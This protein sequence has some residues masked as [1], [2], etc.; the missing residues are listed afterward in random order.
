M[1]KANFRP[2]HDRAADVFGGVQRVFRV[3]RGEAGALAFLVVE[4]IGTKSDHEFRIDLAIQIV[5]D[6]VFRSGAAQHTGFAERAIGSQFRG[7]RIRYVP[8]HVRHV[9]FV[10]VPSLGSHVPFA[11]EFVIPGEIVVLQIV[12]GI[13]AVIDAVR[14]AVKIVFV[15]RRGIIQAENTRRLGVAGPQRHV[16]ATRH[17]E[18]YDPLRVQFQRGVDARVGERID[19]VEQRVGHVVIVRRQLCF[20]SWNREEAANS[21]VE[22]IFNRKVEVEILQNRIEAVLFVGLQEL[23]AEVALRGRESIVDTIETRHMVSP[24]EMA[25][26][27]C[28]GEAFDV[29]DR[30]IEFDLVGKNVV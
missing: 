14:T 11:V 7:N 24:V 15:A 23:L 16:V 4:E 5:D 13:F 18:L 6:R 30:L 2:Q 8:G 28:V 25:G 20:D 22:A 12:I 27:H 21:N 3:F 26:L 9:A 19:G 17:S 1:V 10:H 29:Y